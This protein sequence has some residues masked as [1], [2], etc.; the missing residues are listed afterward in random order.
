MRCNIYVFEK[1]SLT[2]PCKLIFS[3]G[4]FHLKPLIM[5]D[6]LE[7]IVKWSVLVLGIIGL[8]LSFYW[9]KSESHNFEPRTVLVSAL[10][11]VIGSFWNL[12]APKETVAFPTDT[13]E[14]GLEIV[15]GDLE[16]TIERAVKVPDRTIGLS[17]ASR[18]E[19][20]DNIVPYNAEVSL[21]EGSTYTDI[22]TGAVFR[23][24]SVDTKQS[25][26]EYNVSL[27]SD[28]SEDIITD[29]D[30]YEGFFYKDG[31][32]FTFIFHNLRKVGAKSFV[33]IQ[34]KNH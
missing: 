8:I 16:H 23:I 31:Q 1:V 13:L 17:N 7:F 18:E 33:D 14:A 26:V 30:S 3:K 21:T 2:P 4:L 34:I 28:E 25:V 29:E 22:R 5:F 15:R 20:N 27:L 6:T 10:A 11:A 24:W 32:R 9:Y 19:E 12:V